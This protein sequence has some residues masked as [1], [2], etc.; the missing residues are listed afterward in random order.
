[1][2]FKKPPPRENAVANQNF[3]QEAYRMERQSKLIWM[4]AYHKGEVELTA[5]QKMKIE[6]M[7]HSDVCFD[8]NGAHKRPVSQEEPMRRIMHASDKFKRMHLGHTF[9]AHP[10]NE[11][12]QML[13]T[14]AGFEK[15]TYVHLVKKREEQ[16]KTDAIRQAEELEQRPKQHLLNQRLRYQRRKMQW[17]RKSCLPGA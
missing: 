7:C 17:E 2:P 13:G 9:I 4:E 12:R 15:P 14:P 5:M 6:K 8:F 3:L 16:Q 10:P 11:G 1:M